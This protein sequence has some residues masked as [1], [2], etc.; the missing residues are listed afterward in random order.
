MRITKSKDTVKVPVP[1]S[2]TCPVSKGNNTFGIQPGLL[3]R[4]QVLELTQRLNR[5]YLQGF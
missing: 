1:H 4:F 2:G 3:W 5:G